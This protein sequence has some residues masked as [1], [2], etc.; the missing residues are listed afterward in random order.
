MPWRI[1]V[2]I[3]FLDNT[4]SLYKMRGLI[5]LVAFKPIQVGRLKHSIG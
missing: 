5:F 4:A 3:F 1:E 2:S